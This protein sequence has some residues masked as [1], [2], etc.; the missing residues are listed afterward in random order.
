[1]KWSLAE[2]HFG[3]MIR[4]RAGSIYHY[5]IY[6]SDDEVIQFGLAPIARPT[7]SDRDVEVCVSDIDAFLC[8]GFLEVAVPERK[9][10]KKLRT[11]SETVEA[12]RAEIGKKGYSI[13]YNNC[14][15]FAYRCLTGESYCSQTE[16]I[17]DLFRAF[18][19]VDV[20][21]AHT[22]KDTKLKTLYPP[23]RA[24]EISEYTDEKQRRGEYCAWKLFEYALERTFGKKLKKVALTKSGG[25]WKCDACELAYS[26]CDDV[27]CVCVSRKPVELVISADEGDILTDT[28]ISEHSF[29]GKKY[30][31]CIRTDTPER[32]R[33]YEPDNIL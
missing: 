7:L 33:L 31:I 17:R 2:P 13:I 9:E 30:Y 11:P 1:M 8:G 19:I 23:Q 15:H 10:Q 27:V 16:S 3:D 5:G 22:V 12:A 29:N 32:I 26:Y 24:K 4:V 14:E 25:A 18:P 20:Y 28:Y 21:I 6:A